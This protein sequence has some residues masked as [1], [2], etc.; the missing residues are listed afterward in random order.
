MNIEEFMPDPSTTAKPVS[1]FT[2]SE[3]VRLPKLSRVRQRLRRFLNWLARRLVF[4]LTR[5]VV[6]GLENVPTS[7]PVLVIANH[8]G[9]ADDILK[10]AF[11]PRQ[12]EAIAKIELF[13][14]PILGRIME[15]YGVI[16][17]RRGQPDR[18][19]LRA[20]L[21]GLSE[22]R[23][24]MINPEGRESLTGALVL[25]LAITGTQNERLLAN[26]RRLRKT[27]VTV[28]VGQPFQIVEPSPTGE[29]APLSRQD[30]IEQGTQQM[31]Q[32]IAALLPDEYKGVYQEG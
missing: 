29:P 1:E 13:D 23:M 8:I 10:I 21:K 5:P 31:M 19:A 32:R 26:L 4:L 9:D 17:I 24:V 12:I 6:Q 2:R 25:P 28:T 27:P 3:L 16:W 18:Q 22:S 7:G 14:L 11:L 20:A 30:L 15:A